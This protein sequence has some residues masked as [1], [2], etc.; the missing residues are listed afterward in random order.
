P[1]KV[2][3]MPTNKGFIVHGRLQLTRSIRRIAHNDIEPDA[4]KLICQALQQRHQVAVDKDNLILRV[5]DN[6]GQ[7]L[8]K[9]A[10]IQR[11]QNRAH[12]RNSKIQFQMTISVPAKGRDAISPPGSR[13]LKRVRQLLDALAPIS[14]GIAM[15]A[16][17][18]ERDNLFPLKEPYSTLEKMRQG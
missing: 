2:F 17:G 18:C 16:M 5:I 6:I 11:V 10:D 9:Q 3:S 12:T 4:R 1:G 7:L 14:I 15:F 13:C 8:C